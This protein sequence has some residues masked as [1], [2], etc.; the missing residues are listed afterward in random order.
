MP[1][2]PVT[3]AR[4]VSLS[5]RGETSSK[6]EP[7]IDR[8]SVSF[9]VAD[10]DARPTS[11]GSVSSQM[12][13]GEVASTSYGTRVPLPGGA[14]AFVGVMVRAVAPFP[15]A[16]V[17]WNPSRVADPDG[18]SLVGLEQ[19][20]DELPF[21]VAAAAEVVS[22][23]VPP[24]EFSV[25]RLDVA[26]DFHTSLQTASALI[27]SLAPIHRPWARKNLVHAD[28]SRNGAQTLMVGSGAGVARLYDKYAETGGVA[29]EGTLRLEFEARRGWLARYGEVAMLGD[30]GDEA[31]ARLAANR[32]EWS[33]MG[34][35]VCT[36]PDLVAALASSGLSPAQQRS[37]L[38]WLYMEHLGYDGGLARATLARFR[39]VR[40]DLNIGALSVAAEGSR[41][42][43]R[44]DWD[45]GEVV[46]RLA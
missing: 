3:R 38:G 2:A 39:R 23:S 42:V 41:F 37:F 22:S 43:S 20:L 27:R 44:L 33:A 26:R 4:P 11:W 31:V 5:N 21:V 10:F 36:L 34:R 19:A 12:R 18:C 32:F 45:S 25:T 8:L 35:E 28:P 40:R 13:D 15:V 46:T 30:L 1:P 9:P 14:S 17:E 16:K 24:A 6:N 29:P 7:G